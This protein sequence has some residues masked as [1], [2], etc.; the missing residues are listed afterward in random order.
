MKNILILFALVFLCGC[1][2]QYLIDH[3]ID[4]KKSDGNYAV[5]VD[6]GEII[7]ENYPLICCETPEDLRVAEG[8][9]VDPLWRRMRIYY[10]GRG[11]DGNV[12]IH[13][14]AG[15]GKIFLRFVD[16]P[17][18]KADIFLKNLENVLKAYG[19][20]LEYKK[21]WKGTGSILV[22]Y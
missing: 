21:V 15:V 13:W 17:D 19:L 2:G 3:Y 18:D 22:S 20:S 16:V 9:E 1:H 8:E 12:S 4:V 6:L 11:F 7:K 14:F 5:G 10:G